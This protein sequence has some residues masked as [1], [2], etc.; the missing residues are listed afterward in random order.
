MVSQQII[1]NANSWS[2]FKTL[3]EPLGNKQRGD[4]FELL[5]ELYLQ[6]DPVYRSK[7]KEFWHESNLPSRVRSK[8]GLPS[9]EIGVD[10]V[11][12][13]NDGEYWSIQCKYHHDP[14]RNLG[15]KELELFLG[16]STRVCKGKFSNLLAVS[17]AHGYSRNLKKYAPEVQYCLSD[18]FQ[19][20]DIEFFTQARSVL[21]KKTPKFT[22]YK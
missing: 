17:S 1:R 7:L 19:A 3:L 4:A 22:V 12:E 5:T 20:L 21:K 18:R 10:L 9:P 13:T 6:I 16:I 15:F 2:E 8:L 14:T 11:A